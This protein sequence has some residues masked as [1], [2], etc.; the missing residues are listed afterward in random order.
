VSMREAV[1]YDYEKRDIWK[2]NEYFLII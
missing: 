1:V 2:R